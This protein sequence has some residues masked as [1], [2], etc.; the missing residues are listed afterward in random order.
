MPALQS[1]YMANH[2]TET[3]VLKVMGDLLR[4]IDDDNVAAL[5][6][7]DLFAAGFCSGTAFLPSLFGCLTRPGE[8]VWFGTKWERE[9]KP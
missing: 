4:M 3:A 9:M 1:A 2:S 5:V 6:L 7:L 8:G